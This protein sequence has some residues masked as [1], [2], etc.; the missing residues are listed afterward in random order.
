MRQDRYQ[1]P[2]PNVA[3]YHKDPPNFT[4]M[5]KTRGAEWFN[6]FRDLNP[7]CEII[8]TDKDLSRR[9]L[10]GVNLQGVDISGMN[11]RGADLSLALLDDTKCSETAFI[12]AKLDHASMKGALLEDTK[13][14]GASLEHTDFQDATF[15]GV[16]V[17]EKFASARMVG[18]D[19]REMSAQSRLTPG[20]F[21]QRCRLDGRNLRSQDLR[22][23]N[24][25][26]ANLEDADFCGALFDHTTI[27]TGAKLAGAKMLFRDYHDSNAHTAQTSRMITGEK[28]PKKLQVI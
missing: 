23:T 5:L 28:H 15:K 8:F 19:L 16:C 21:L 22:G 4:R 18:A 17:D 27:F 20:A 2:D 13:F 6:L 25:R 3:R 11:F 26:E 9:N 1:S 14:W 12:E 24:L 7:E 10:R